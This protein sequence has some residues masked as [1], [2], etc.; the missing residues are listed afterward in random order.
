MI[1]GRRLALDALA[2]FMALR[3]DLAWGPMGA[4]LAVAVADRGR[5]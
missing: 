1:V 3:S 2:V 5:S 4:F